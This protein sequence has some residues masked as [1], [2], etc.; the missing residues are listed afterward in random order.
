[1]VKIFGAV[2]IVF[3]GVA[4]GF[5]LNKRA[6]DALVQ[7][8][9]FI[10]LVRYLRNEIDCFSMPIPLALARCPDSIFQKCGIGACNNI[11]TVEELICECEMQGE[12]LGEVM[13]RFAADV[14]RGYK[15]E[16][17]ALC[18]R[19]VKRLESYRASLAGQLPAK[20][21][22]NGTLCLCFALALVILLI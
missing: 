5:L 10:E 3:C 13:E 8:E 1:M 7:T 11:R 16:Q 19:T 9:G 14:G 15:H 6:R 2:L 20:Q 4:F 12:E 17:L 18:E 21:K 22:L